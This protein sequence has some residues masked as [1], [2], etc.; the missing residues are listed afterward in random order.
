MQRSGRCS[1]L[2]AGVASMT[3]VDV[4]AEDGQG[5][6]LTS[7]N[8][9]NCANKELT[10]LH[11]CTITFEMSTSD[12]SAVCLSKVAMPKNSQKLSS[13]GAPSAPPAPIL[14]MELLDNAGAVLVYANGV[15]LSPP[16][17]PTNAAPGQGGNTQGGNTQ[18]GGLPPQGGN[19][20]GGN[21][22]QGGNGGIQP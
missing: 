21:N 22:T 8:L 5:K 10:G 6:T 16:P 17:L 2:N 9:S 15:M 4:H 3:V 14:S 7:T 19:M 1:V 18:G 20:Q 11:A 13:K 12:D